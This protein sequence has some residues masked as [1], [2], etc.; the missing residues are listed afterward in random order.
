MHFSDALLKQPLNEGICRAAEDANVE[1]DMGIKAFHLELGLRK[2]S[3]ER[4]Y[5]YPLN[6]VP[7]IERGDSSRDTEMAGTRK[8]IENALPRLPQKT[9]VEYSRNPEILGIW[10]KNSSAKCSSDYELWSPME[11]G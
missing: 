2:A 9:L 7:N 6:Y 10:G 8:N 3:V 1:I 4:F 5:S 11:Q